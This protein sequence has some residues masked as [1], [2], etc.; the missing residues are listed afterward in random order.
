[1]T[2]PHEAILERIAEHPHTAWALDKI[3]QL[4]T[5]TSIAFT[6][7]SLIKAVKELP[8]VQ[9]HLTAT[10]AI[11]Q[12]LT[13]GIYSI[14]TVIGSLGVVLSIYMAGKWRAFRAESERI[15]HQTDHEYRMAQ[16]R[17]N[18]FAKI[19]ASEEKTWDAK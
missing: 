1:M 5:P 19:Q 7:G 3:A 14:A 4:S 9:H 13:A 8:A 11:V 16:L 10:E 2:V 6:A 17:S 12:I 15:K 18:E